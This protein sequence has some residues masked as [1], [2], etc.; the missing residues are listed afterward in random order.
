MVY[1]KLA[2]WAAGLVTSNVAHVVFLTSDVAFTKSLGKALP[3]RV[4]RQITLGDCSHDVA[5]RFVIKQLNSNPDEESINSKPDGESSAMKDS[6]DDGQDAKS[7][8]RSSQ[9]SELDEVVGQLGGRL[10]DLAFLA[11]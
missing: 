3:G 4:F 9:M 11:R 7:D 2:E 6:E 5:K 8:G 1:E 10:T